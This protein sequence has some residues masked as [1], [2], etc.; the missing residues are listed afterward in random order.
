MYGL[1]W[2]DYQALIAKQEGRC[3]ICKKRRRLVVDHSHAD[4]YVRG[5]LCNGCNRA[6]GCFDDDVTILEDAIQYL[7]T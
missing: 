3:A 6:I 1:L 5:L 7:Q 2:E 4:G